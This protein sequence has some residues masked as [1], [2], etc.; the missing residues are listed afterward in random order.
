MSY[1]IRKS[2]ILYRIIKSNAR[3][4]PIA[5]MQV[6]TTC[7]QD[8]CKNSALSYTLD[9]LERAGK[10]LA[11]CE[12]KTLVRKHHDEIQL[13]SLFYSCM[14]ARVYPCMQENT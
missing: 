4:D 12:L 1:G 10:D 11:S 8:D 2:P 3:L 7:V 13:H 9:G 14:K 6:P 5:I